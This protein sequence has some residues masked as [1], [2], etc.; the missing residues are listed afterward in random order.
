MIICGIDPSTVCTGVSIL[1]VESFDPLQLKLIAKTNLS[2]PPKLRFPHPYRKRIAMLDL[3]QAFMDSRVAAVDFFVF[4]NYS[5]GSPGR[6]DDLAECCSL[7]KYYLCVHDKSFDVIAPMTVKK[8]VGGSGKSDKEQVKEGLSR[9]LTNY[10]ELEFNTLDE[11]DSAA[12][13]IAY[14]MA[15]AEAENESRKSRKVVQLDS[16]RNTRRRVK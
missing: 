10:N 5:Y 12:I 1:E 15:S 13:A 8:Y 6:L 3:F 9:F 16:K 2:I 11:S 4:E 7:L 14:L